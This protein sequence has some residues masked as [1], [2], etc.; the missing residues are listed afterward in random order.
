[1]NK[2]LIINEN[3]MNIS[4]ANGLIIKVGYDKKKDLEMV[5]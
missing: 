1:V 5:G 2:D 4:P 3:K